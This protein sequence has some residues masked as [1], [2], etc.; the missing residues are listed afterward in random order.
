MQII[1]IALRILRQV[2][3]IIYPIHATCRHPNFGYWLPIRANSGNLFSRSVMLQIQQTDA[4][5]MLVS[6]HINMREIRSH[7]LF[8]KR[9]L[10]YWPP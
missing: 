9:V 3:K 6:F 2:Q 1:S 7:Y 10:I 4:Q 8:A 5:W